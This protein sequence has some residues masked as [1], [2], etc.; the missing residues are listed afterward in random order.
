MHLMKHL[1]EKLIPNA[2]IFRRK[3]ESQSDQRMLLV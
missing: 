2:I 1:R 3:S